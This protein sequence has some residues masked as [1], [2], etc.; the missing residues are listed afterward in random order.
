MGLMR[1]VLRDRLNRTFYKGASEWTPAVGEALEF[2]KTETAIF[3]KRQEAL[4]NAHVYFSFEENE[5]D[6]I[7]SEDYPQKRREQFNQLLGDQR[8]N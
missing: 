8:S 2:E 5:T 3:H 4:P 1:I 7:F 6:N